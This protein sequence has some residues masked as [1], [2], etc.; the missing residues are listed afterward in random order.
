MEHWHFST[1]DSQ[2]KP[3]GSQVAEARAVPAILVIAAVHVVIVR[4]TQFSTGTCQEEQTAVD[5]SGRSHLLPS[6]EAFMHHSS[7]NST[8]LV[9]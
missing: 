2:Y 3:G 7:Q 6:A 4:R 5:L 8:E 9:S 1:S